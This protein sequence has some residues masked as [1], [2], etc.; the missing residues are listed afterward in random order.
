MNEMVEQLQ[1]QQALEELKKKVLNQLLTRDA[2]ERLGRIKT[3]NP[4]LANGVELYLLQ[5][6]QA[7]KLTSIV[8][9]SKLKGLLETLSQKKET[10]I[11]RI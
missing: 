6:Y 4:Q 7:G 3:V 5:L 9:D 10:T 11:R 1:Q 8:D 2:V